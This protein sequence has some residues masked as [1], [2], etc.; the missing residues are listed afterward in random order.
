MRDRW[1]ALAL[2][3]LLAATP[4]GAGTLSYSGYSV[5]NAQ[6]VHITD[7]ALGVSDEYAGAGQILLNNVQGD[8]R[9]AGSVPAWCIDISNWLLS[10]STYATY[11]FIPGFAGLSEIVTGRIGALIQ[12]FGAAQAA[13]GANASAAMQMAI[14]E[15]EYG[16]GLKITPDN[17]A[18]TALADTYVANVNSGTWEL[19][20]GYQLG[21]LHRGQTTNQDLA[22]ISDVPEPA[23]LAI[24][25]FALLGL[26]IVGHPRRLQCPVE[27][28]LQALNG[29]PT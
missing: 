6:N 15:V 11:D 20:G 3:G 8:G 25:G 29:V 4:A 1:S 28:L 2:V 12:N 13:N 24:F 21:L 18:L 9:N 23:S 7:V 16:P 22:F 27:I 5:T 26:G 19:T 14:W 10:D 17:G